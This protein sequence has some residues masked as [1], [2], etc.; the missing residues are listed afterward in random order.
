MITGLRA[1]PRRRW[2]AAA[3]AFPVLAFVFAAPGGHGL[4]GAW[5]PWW[6]WPWLV[7]TGALASLVLAS[8]L[9]A[10]GTGKMIDVGC[11]PCAAAAGLALGAALFAHASA[12]ASPFLAGVA[13]L[14]AVFAFRQ[15]LTDARA[16][17]AGQPPGQGA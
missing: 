4:P 2:L 6:T 15:R 8:Y 11:S 10:P 9:A 17:P 13:T 5:A 3:A 14:L 7:I 1:W 16:C 12:P